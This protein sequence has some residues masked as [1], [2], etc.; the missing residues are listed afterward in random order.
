[1]NS[2]DFG[3]ADGVR[4]DDPLSSPA[5]IEE[6]LDSTAERSEPV[7]SFDDFAAD[8]LV[9]TKPPGPG[10]PESAGWCIAVMAFQIGFGLVAGAIGAVILIIGS[11]DRPPAEVVRELETLK[12]APRLFL[13]GVP[14]I[15]AFAFLIGLALLRLGRG[16]ARKLNLAR[17]SLTQTLVLCSAIL[18]VGYVADLVWTQSNHLW[19]EL[20]K[21]IVWIEE[22]NRSTNI[23]EEMARM[24]GA[25]LLLLLL[26]LAVT[27]AIGEEFMLRGLIG[28]GLVA[29]WGVVWG[30]LWTSAFFAL[31][32]IFPAH[33]AAVFPMGI[34]MHVIYLT[35]RSLWAPVLFHF[36]NNSMASVYTYAGLSGE[37]SSA[38]GWMAPLGLAYAVGACCLL[39]KYRTRYVDETGHEFDPGYPTVEA[40]PAE[41]PYR[42]TAPESLLV[43]SLAGAIVLG[44]VV[45]IASDFAVPT[46]ADGVEE[47]LDP[48]EDAEIDHRR[49]ACGS[50][51]RGC[52]GSARSLRGCAGV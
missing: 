34:M 7:P 27:P 43:G 30:V 8:G 2:A 33:V 15:F 38:P 24:Q 42:R 1:M 4:R 20:T 32:H 21:D 46:P 23:M 17:P 39:W 41:S 31:L 5:E 13:L 25:P 3:P 50:S 48:I 45:L 22:F 10:L 18:P 35:T 40:P 49:Y 52:D 37:E 26:C 6:F 16:R 44:Q 11:G 9:A 14:N 36:L 47:V 28:R 19:E 51:G 12:G 29:R